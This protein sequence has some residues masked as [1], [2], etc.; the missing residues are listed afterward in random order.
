VSSV[1]Y[2]RGEAGMASAANRGFMSNA[3]FSSGGDS[4]PCSTR[5]GRGLGRGIV[6]AIRRRCADTPRR[7]VALQ[8]PVYGLGPLKAAGARSG[9]TAAHFFQLRPA[10]ERLA[11]RRTDLFPW[12]DET[13]KLVKPDVLVDG[14]TSFRLGGTTFITT[15]AAYA[16][17]ASCCWSR[18]S[19]R[20]SPNTPVRRTPVRRQRRLE[21]LACRDRRLIPRA[22]V[23]V[24]GHG[25]RR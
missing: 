11:Q 9:R 15:P 16:P 7:G 17:D 4:V 3:G 19:A 10:A 12:V 20:C 24:P 8:R 18:T 2:F 25:P 14:D 5:S 13:T 1:W 6:D 22:D 21:A 23:V